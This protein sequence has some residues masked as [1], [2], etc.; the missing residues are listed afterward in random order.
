MIIISSELIEIMEE[1]K[2]T[3]AKFSKAEKTFFK[4]LGK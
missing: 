3:I 1:I 4:R 2:A